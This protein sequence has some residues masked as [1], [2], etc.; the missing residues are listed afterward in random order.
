[1]NALA[2]LP[3]PLCGDLI[4]EYDIVI[5]VE[6][7]EGERGAVGFYLSVPWGWIPCYTM[8]NNVIPCYTMV[9]HANQ[10]YFKLYHVIPCY[11]MLNNVIP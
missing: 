9:Y 2:L 8:L 10:C 1:M 11:T 7:G 5:G 6:A 3:P 4:V